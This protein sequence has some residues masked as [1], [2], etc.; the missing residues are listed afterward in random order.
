MNTQPDHVKASR[1]EGGFALVAAI[2]ACLIL[3]ALAMLVISLSTGDLRTSSAVVGG[4]R[5]LLATESGVHNLTQTFDPAG[6]NFGLNSTWQNVDAANDPGS[7][8][9]YT[10]SAASALAPMPLP[11][12]SVEAGQG[13]GMSRYNVAVDGRNTLYNAQMQVSVGV[14]YGPV[15]ISTTYK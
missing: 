1:S 3:M 8:Y 9:R 6:T 7:Q 10:S 5:A 4:K 2:I 13:W 12:Y 14:G 15:P 11:G